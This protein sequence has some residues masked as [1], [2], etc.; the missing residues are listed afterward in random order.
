MCKYLLLFLSLPFAVFSQSAVIT[1]VYFTHSKDT[2]KS[3]SFPQIN[4]KVETPEMSRIN[5][6][7]KAS[8]FNSDTAKP[9]ISLLESIY[10]K[11]KSFKMKYT[12]NH[13][14]NGLL[15][16][17]IQNTSSKGDRKLPIY[18]NFDLSAGNLVT[19]KTFFKTKND[20]FSFAQAVIPTIIDSVQLLEQTIDKNNLNYGKIIEWLNARLSKFQN[21]YLSDYSMTDREIIVY[22]DCFIPNSLLSYNH[23]YQVSFF[24]KT[25]KNVFKPDI[26]KRLSN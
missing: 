12:I 22:F 13:N 21:S 26:I 8:V 2:I 24:Y 18:L 9:V 15:S 23:T 3:I 14:K 4:C 17:T 5:N 20:S 7:I 25:L 6:I 10:K 1:P 16:I 11:D 19:L